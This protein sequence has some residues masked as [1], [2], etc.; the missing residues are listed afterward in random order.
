[1]MMVGVRLKYLK[2]GWNRKD[3][4]GNKDLERGELGQG[5]GT[6]KGGLKNP[7]TNYYPLC[8]HTVFQAI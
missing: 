1:M 8:F 2:K 6:L 7:L 3:G 5:V 4:T